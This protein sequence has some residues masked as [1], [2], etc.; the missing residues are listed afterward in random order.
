MPDSVGAEDGSLLELLG[1]GNGVATFVPKSFV[2][3]SFLSCA[4]VK[5]FLLPLDAR[6]GGIYPSTRVEESTLGP[7]PGQVFPLLARFTPHK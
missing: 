1:V 6:R 7:T 5:T 2:P 3:K 4:E